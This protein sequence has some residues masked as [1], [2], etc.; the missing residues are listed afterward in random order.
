MA[1]THPGWRS[2]NAL[3][4]FSTNSKALA[5]RRV[6]YDVDDCE[7][8]CWRTGV[9][10]LLHLDDGLVCQLMDEREPKSSPTRSICRRLSILRNGS[11][12]WSPRSDWKRIE[13]GPDMECACNCAV[14]IP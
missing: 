11:V 6:P 7:S 13:A 10:S 8:R 12:L 14:G 5:V 9:N 4:F 3:K 1:S 2:R